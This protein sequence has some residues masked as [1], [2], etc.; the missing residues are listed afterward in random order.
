MLEKDV[1]GLQNGGSSEVQ[2]NRRLR[3]W[4]SNVSKGK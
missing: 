4:P 2:F 3:M 1:G